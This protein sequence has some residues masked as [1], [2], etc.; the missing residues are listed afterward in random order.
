MVK[1]KTKS[2]FEY[3][4]DELKIQD[5]RVLD[6][7]VDVEDGRVESVSRLIRLILTPEQKNALYAHCADESG[8]VPPER[9]TEEIFE[10]LKNSGEEAKNS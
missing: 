7:I 1:G 10:I 9:T 4:I 3:E 6:Y 5:Q 8:R 2:G